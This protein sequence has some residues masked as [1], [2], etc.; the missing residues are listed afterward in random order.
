VAAEWVCRKGAERKGVLLVA[1]S[2]SLVIERQAVWLG[3]AADP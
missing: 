3:N 2:H 1:P